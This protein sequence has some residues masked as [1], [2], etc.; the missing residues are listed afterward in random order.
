[1]TLAEIGTLLIGR[2]VQRLDLARNCMIRTFKPL[3]ALLNL[4]ELNLHSTGITDAA[5]LASLR[6]LHR[7]DLS[8]TGVID[9]GP[10]GAL[11]NLL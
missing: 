5:G 10:L 11:P 2:S 4:C 6:K 9:V 8:S 7:L 1:M 3:P